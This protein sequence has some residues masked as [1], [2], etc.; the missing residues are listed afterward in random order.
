M[1]DYKALDESETEANRG[2]AKGRRWRRITS[3]VLI[4]LACLLAVVSVV[5]VFARNQLLN[6]DAYVSTMAPL[7]ANPAI[8]TQIATRVS[9]NLVARTDLNQKVKDAL[10]AKAGFLATPITS[11]VQKVTYATTLKVVQSPK[12]EQLWV[13]VNRAA[14]KQ[15]VAVLT[16][17]SEGSSVSTKDGKITIDLSKVEA[18]VKEKLDA[19]GIT[20]FDK[21]PAVKGLNYV[22]FQS[23]DLVRIQKL[24]NFLNKLAVVL[25]IITLLLFAG[26]VVLTRN[27]RKGLVRAATGLAVSMALILVL[28][29]VA[30]N[31]YITGLHPPQSP[32]AQTA[33][34]DTVTATLR[35]T[36]GII[37]VVAALLAIGAVVAGNTW[38]RHKVG[39]LRTVGWVAGGPV[40]D[41]VALHRKALQWSVLAIGLLTLVLWSNPTTL[42]AVVVVLITL[43]VVGLVGL[44]AGRG[45]RSAMAGSAGT[46]ATQP[47]KTTSGE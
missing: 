17:S 3:W 45:P 43:A 36:V 13:T 15:L 20:V 41:F 9:E 42:V 31:H 6:T 29:A 16:G 7:A 32:E 46:I 10:P 35:D 27:R 37:L 26:A 47:E 1:T 40:H 24:V 5:V 28:Y 19:Q 21:V 44:F 22:L 12:F 11:E 39:D 34:L 8:Q 33:L 2:P 38:V 23:K 30:R 14:S 4:V 18:N 25:P